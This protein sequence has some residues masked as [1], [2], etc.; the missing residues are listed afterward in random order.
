MKS[1]VYIAGLVALDIERCHL[2]PKGLAAMLDAWNLPRLEELIAA[3]NGFGEEGAER[4]AVSK[5]WSKLR[6]LDL[7]KNQLNKKG[8]IA[9]AKGP[10]LA[11]IAKI[12]LNER[13]SEDARKALAE[14]KTLAKSLVY[15]RGKR[16]ARAKA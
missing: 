6:V 2:G 16:L 8:I 5:V 3:S 12:L 9:L 14:S 10:G 15:F 11:G 7:T 4:I 13:D 1:S